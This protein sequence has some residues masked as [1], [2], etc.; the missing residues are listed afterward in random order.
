MCNNPQATGNDIL[1]S[2][3]KQV[4]VK[5]KIKRLKEC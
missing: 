1:S 2:F 5:D 3:A 4:K